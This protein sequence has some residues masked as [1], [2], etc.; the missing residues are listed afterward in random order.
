MIDLAKD[1]MERFL[2]AIQT[3]PSVIDHFKNIEQEFIVLKQLSQYSN[4][5]DYEK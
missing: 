3:K 1:R 2:K 4:F 5:D